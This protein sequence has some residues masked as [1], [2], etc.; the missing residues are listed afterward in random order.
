MKVNVKTKRLS[1][2]SALRSTWKQGINSTATM[3]YIKRV[4]ADLTQQNMKF[5]SLLLS[6]FYSKR[7][8]RVLKCFSTKVFKSP[9]YI[10][11]YPSYLQGTSKTLYEA[12]FSTVQS[13]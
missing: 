10:P 3:P 1:K 8:S 4:Q 6:G 13:F 9:N 11:S 12:I 2:V 5:F 7:S